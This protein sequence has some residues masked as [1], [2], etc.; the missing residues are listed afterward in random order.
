LSTAVTNK[1]QPR[2]DALCL[3]C[4]EGRSVKSGHL[5]EHLLRRIKRPGYLDCMFLDW[6]GLNAGHPQPDLIGRHIQFSSA[7]GEP[8]DASF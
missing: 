6:L 4:G 1:T 8:H 5:R 7:N 2:E 3:H